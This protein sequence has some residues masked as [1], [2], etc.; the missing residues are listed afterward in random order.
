MP[1]ASMYALELLILTLVQ[2]LPTCLQ[3]S[4]FSQNSLNTLLP[5]PLSAA[6]SFAQSDLLPL[7]PVLQRTN[8]R[9]NTVTVQSFKA[10][11]RITTLTFSRFIVK[12]RETHVGTKIEINAK[13]YGKMKVDFVPDICIAKY[14]LN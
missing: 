2:H 8:F 9:S 14:I 4:K 7:C 11:K 3:V 6:L 1:L 13:S 12:E 5:V 10:D